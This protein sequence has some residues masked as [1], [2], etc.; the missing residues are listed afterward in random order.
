VLLW[1]AQD[2]LNVL[3]MFCPGSIEYEDVI[4]IYN[5]KELVNSCDILSIILMNVFGALVK[6]KS[7]NNHIKMPCLDLKVVFH[8]L[9]C[10]IKT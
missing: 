4:Q 9:S 10:S 8:M 5:H 3:Q 1:G 2:M 7:M 6:P